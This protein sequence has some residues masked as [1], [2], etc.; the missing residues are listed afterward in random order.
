MVARHQPERADGA[1]RTQRD[2]GRQCQGRL[3]RG[4]Y[5]WLHH[6]EAAHAAAALERNSV[7]AG[8]APSAHPGVPQRGDGHR[9]RRLG[10]RRRSEWPELARRTGPASGW[11]DVVAGQNARQPGRGR[12][13]DHRENS[14]WAIGDTEQQSELAHWNGRT[15][16]WKSI[17]PL[18]DLYE[19]GGIA[20]APGRI[21]FTV[22][23]E[24]PVGRQQVPVSLKLAGSTWKPV[25]VRA[26]S[27][28]ELNAVSFAPGGAGWAAGATGRSTLILRWSGKAW[29]RIASPS[30]GSID[31]LDGL[32]FSSA[33]NGLAVGSSGS[34]TL[35][36][37]W[38]GSSWGT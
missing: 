12:R 34:R 7:A 36:L 23:L 26:P 20:T 14:A 21:A 3:G 35:I 5:R 38:N 11:H 13:G 24:Y 6:H 8:H 22:G 16:A 1:R 2:R 31:A 9:E 29:T 27:I 32:G 28:S 30:D 19:L 25:T 37:H 33:K 15:W 18:Q 4:L 17:L 10:G